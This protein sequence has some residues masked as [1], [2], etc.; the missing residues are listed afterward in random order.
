MLDSLA[1]WRKHAHYVHAN[2]L[3]QAYFLSVT[4]WHQLLGKTAVVG[5]EEHKLQQ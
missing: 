5:G 1:Q 3:P 4:E 2:A